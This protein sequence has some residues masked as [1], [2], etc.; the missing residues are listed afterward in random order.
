MVIAAMVLSVITA[1]MM[2]FVG[3][4]GGQIRHSELR[5]QIGITP[6][7]QNIQKESGDKD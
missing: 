7:E 5:S 1:G 3:K 6:T 2:A 4:T